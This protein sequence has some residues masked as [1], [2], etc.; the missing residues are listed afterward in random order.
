MLSHR[1]DHQTPGPQARDCSTAYVQEE[2]EGPTGLSLL[3][4]RGVQRARPCMEEVAGPHSP[5]DKQTQF[6]PGN[7][8]RF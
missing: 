6:T 1:H 3:R 7:R 8:G 5:A 4:P 2:A